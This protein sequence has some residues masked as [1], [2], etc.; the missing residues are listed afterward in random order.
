MNSQFISI[1]GGCLFSVKRLLLGWIIK[2]IQFSKKKIFKLVE[3]YTNLNC[4]LLIICHCLFAVLVSAVVSLAVPRKVL[5]DAVI[6][7]PE[8]VS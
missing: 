1:P 8:F 3:L 7:K 5:K 2:S 6:K 4:L